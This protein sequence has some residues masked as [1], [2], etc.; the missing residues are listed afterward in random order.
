MQFESG[1]NEPS[2]DIATKVF[3]TLRSSCRLAK[4]GGLAIVV[5]FVDRQFP[6][7]SLLA[8]LTPGER[9]MVVNFRRVYEG[10]AF[11]L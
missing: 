5:V 11:A 10:Q 6:R 3:V 4:R 9:E 8:R 2:N 1:K 7:L